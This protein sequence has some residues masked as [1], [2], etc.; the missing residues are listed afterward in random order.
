MGPSGQNP[1]Q[2][3]PGSTI[4]QHYSVLSRFGPALGPV[5]ASFRPV[6]NRRWPVF[7]WF[8]TGFGPVFGRF[9]AGFGPESE[10]SVPRPGASGSP[11]RRLSY[12]AR[13]YPSQGHT[14]LPG[15][16]GAQEYPGP[17]IRPAYL[18]SLRVGNANLN[19]Y[20]GFGRFW[21]VFR[22]NLAPRPVPTGRARKMVQNAPKIS[23]G[24]QF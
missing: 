17:P 12:P 16:P 7:G 13:G 18:V 1:A 22:P 8:S 15:M 11:L 21:V 5:L 2:I 24:D 14:R 19:L 3:R 20:F 9:W 6:L 4:V 23:P 10:I